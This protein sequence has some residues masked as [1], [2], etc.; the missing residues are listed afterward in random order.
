MSTRYPFP[1]IPDGWFSVAASEDVGLGEV[2]PLHY[3]DR[4]LVAFRGEDGAV[5]VFDAHCP[6]LGAH[7]GFGGRVCGEGIVCP[8]H[9]WRFD[10]DGRS[11]RCPASTGNRP[12]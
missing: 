1:A 4:D 2:K 11:S 5:R 3:L 9:G 8:F 7:L 10:G 6:H 12:G